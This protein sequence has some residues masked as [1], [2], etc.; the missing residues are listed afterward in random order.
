[1]QQCFTIYQFTQLTQILQL[2]FNWL[3]LLL[4]KCCIFFWSYEETWLHISSGKQ[5]CCINWQKGEMSWCF[6]RYKA[7]CMCMCMCIFAGGG[8][9]FAMC[10]TSPTT[11]VSTP[12]NNLSSFLT[13]NHLPFPLSEDMLVGS[14]RGS[15]LPFSFLNLLLR[16]CVHLLNVCSYLVLLML[17]SFTTIFEYECELFK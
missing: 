15:L 1:M 16:S 7:Y 5:F 12:K 13:I 9:G 10:T 11:Q 6:I 2:H 17:L 3:N 8:D 4:V 14:C